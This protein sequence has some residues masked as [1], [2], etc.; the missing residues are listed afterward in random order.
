MF[1]IIQQISGWLCLVLWIAKYFD[2]IRCFHQANL[3]LFSCCFSLMFVLLL[4]TRFVM[5]FLFLLD[6]RCIIYSLDCCK[7]N[8]KL[9]LFVDLFMRQSLIMIEHLLFW[10]HSF[11]YLLNG[12]YSRYLFYECS[13]IRYLLRL[14]GYLLK[15][16][17]MVFS[18]RISYCLRCLIAKHFCW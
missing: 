7:M 1:Q 9:I 15:K 10:N 5:N 2:W 3:C 14:W 12:K 4:I 17:R 13:I 16:V 6:C 11:F 18:N 8:C